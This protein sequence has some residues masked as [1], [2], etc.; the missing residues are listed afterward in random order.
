MG[1]GR[2]RF[3]HRSVAAQ[4]ADAHLLDD[5]VMM[6]PMLPHLHEAMAI[7]MPAPMMI[8]PAIVAPVVPAHIAIVRRDDQACGLRRSDDDR[9]HDGDRDK[10]RKNKV[11]HSGYPP[12][13]AF[14]HVNS[15]GG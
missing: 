2:R 7:M 14:A 3:W 9:G 12:L 15:K 10:C 11:F 8:A 4:F 1:P 6:A 5:P 13:L